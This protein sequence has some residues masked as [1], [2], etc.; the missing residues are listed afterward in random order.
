MAQAWWEPESEV[1]SPLHPPPGPELLLQKGSYHFYDGRPAEDGYR[2]LWRNNG[3]LQ[4]RPA[5]FDNLAELQMLLDLGRK[6]G[7]D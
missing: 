1:C 4:A 6:E 3:K 7:W 5:R 2:V